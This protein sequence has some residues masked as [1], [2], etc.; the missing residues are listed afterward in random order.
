MLIILN[1]WDTWI[2]SIKW[3]LGAWFNLTLSVTGS[4]N[5]YLPDS[6]EAWLK[7][8]LVNRGFATLLRKR[9]IEAALEIDADGMHGHAQ[10]WPWM[11]FRSHLY[12]QRKFS[13]QVINEQRGWRLSMST[14]HCNIV[15]VQRDKCQIYLSLSVQDLDVLS[16]VLKR[17][18]ALKVLDCCLNPVWLRRCMFRELFSITWY[19]VNT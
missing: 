1:T 10:V 17:E 6:A 8:L 13:N 11:C 12:V 19:L 7:G 3:K 15:N 4:Q 16:Q 18:K 5:G 2:T 9:D 14:V